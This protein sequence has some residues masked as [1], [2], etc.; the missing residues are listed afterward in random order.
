MVATDQYLSKQRMSKISIVLIFLISLVPVHYLLN[1]NFRLWYFSLFLLIV[2]SY[3]ITLVLRSNKAKNQNLNQNLYQEPSLSLVIFSLVGAMS[4]TLSYY[5]FDRFDGVPIQSNLK[6]YQKIIHQYLYFIAFFTLPTVYLFGRFK[7]RYFFNTYFVLNIFALL[8]IG[9]HSFRLS[10]NRGGLANFFDPI[11]SFDMAFTALALLSLSYAFYLRNKVAYLYILA[12]C[13]SVFLLMMHGSR[14]AWLGLPVVIIILSC[15]YYKTQ[16]KKL[17]LVF[18]LSLSFLVSN[19]FLPSSPIF[20]RIQHLKS[21]A[22]LIESENFDNSTG[23]RLLLWKNAI[24]LFKQSPVWGVGMYHIEENNC[25][26]YAEK[27]LEQCFQHQ[28]SII[29]QELAAHG[30]VGLMGLILSF[31]VPLVYFARHL[32]R[33]QNLWIK[34]LAVTG[35]IFVIYHAISGLTEYYLFFKYPT[36]LFFFIVASLMSYIQIAKNNP[37]ADLFT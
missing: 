34:N 16:L 20:D 11:I 13:A 10:F 19:L 25:Q 18:A 8:Y 32:W 31:I 5:L 33:Q 6:T 3:S 14:G 23:T 17:G 15:A 26:L 7:A 36:F 35:I 22:A 24:E 27:R 30:I 28:H 9:F 21:D 12:S 4:I 29:F 2:Y 1:D 37:R